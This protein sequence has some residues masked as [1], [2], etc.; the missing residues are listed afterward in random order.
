MS[1]YDAIIVGARCAGAPTAML[2]AQRGHRVLLV[3]RA[4]FPSDTVSTHVVQAPAVAALHR[5]GLLGQVVASG[6]P[7]IETYSFDFGPITITGTPRPAPDG[8]PHAYAPRRTVLDKIL[9]DAAT[10]AGVEVRERFSVEEILVENGVVVGVRGHDH[11]GGSVVERARVVIGADGR[12]SLVAK[13]VQTPS[14]HEKPKLQS[15]YYTY[16]SG[17]PTDGFEI[18]IRP[19]RGWAAA[20][21]NDGLTMV[22]VGWPNAEV[23]AFRSDPEANLLKT[24]DLAPEFAERIRAAKR[25]ERLTG[26]SAPNFF[27]KPYGPGWVLVGD[28]AYNKD[29]ITAQGINDAFRD[30]ESVSAALDQVFRQELTFDDAL[31][32]HQVA[33]DKQVLPIYEFTAQLAS[34]TPPTPEE[35]QV[36]G[37]VYGNQDAMDDFVSINAGTVSPAEFFSPT[38]I[39]RLM[40]PA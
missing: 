30:A 31:E 14:Y 2:L 20:P 23:E 28:A 26:A 16:Y 5:W 4:E 10:K 19:F 1:D 21:T 35:Q 40:T 18:F 27:R 29:P 39:G 38:N 25:E 22:V 15:G 7:P 12:N 11:A 33:R 13:T 36:F 24:F 3:D 32:S 37:A 34:L 8:P 6:L 17:L 9:V